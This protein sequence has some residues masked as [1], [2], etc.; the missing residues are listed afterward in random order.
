MEEYNR[1]VSE[2]GDT[3]LVV[4]F[5]APWCGPCKRISPVL[6]GFKEKYGIKVLKV[7]TTEEDG[8]EVSN[9]FNITSLPTFYFY[10]NKEK[11]AVLK[12]AGKKKLEDLIVIHR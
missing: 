4:D 2:A 8:N 12:G 6:D 3:L 9:N 1:K 5:W 10:K 11:V 7:N